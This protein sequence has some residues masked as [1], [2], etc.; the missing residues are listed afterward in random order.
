M[1][2]ITHVSSGVSVNARSVRM[3]GHIQGTKSAYQSLHVRAGQILK[4][5]CF[6]LG[7]ANDEDGCSIVV[8]LAKFRMVA[9]EEDGEA[10]VK[11]LGLGLTWG[12][13]TGLAAQWR[14]RLTRKR[15]YT[16]FA[17]VVLRLGSE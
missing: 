16:R 14:R 11:L 7:F 9:V 15:L 10:E 17:H 2:G 3:P 12:R 13:E 4:P 6:S 8:I 5:T 1:D